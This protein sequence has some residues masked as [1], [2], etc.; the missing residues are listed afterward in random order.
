MGGGVLAVEER[1]PALEAGG[2][3]EVITEVTAVIIDE[4]F[5]GAPLPLAI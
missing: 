2:T 3:V 5:T 1:P 4:D